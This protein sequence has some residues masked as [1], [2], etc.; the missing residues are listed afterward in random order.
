MSDCHWGTLETQLHKSCPGGDSCIAGLAPHVYTSPGSDS[1]LSCTLLLVCC[2]SSA[3]INWGSAV[4]S[5]FSYNVSCFWLPLLGSWLVHCAAGDRPL[6]QGCTGQGLAAT[7]P[8]VQLSLLLLQLPTELNSTRLA[9]FYRRWPLH[10]GPQG[11]L[12]GPSQIPV[13]PPKHVSNSSST[14]QNEGC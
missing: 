14:P 8:L 7:P 11:F 4:S 10:S 5:V 13:L 2:L 9:G 3:M 6:S 1:V 12:S